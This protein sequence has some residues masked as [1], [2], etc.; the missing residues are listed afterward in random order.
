MVLPKRR[1]KDDSIIGGNGE[2]D[3]DCGRVRGRID[4]VIICFIR[5]PGKSEPV[6][7]CG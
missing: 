2:S 7:V 1:Y 4:Q 6:P 3:G 5:L